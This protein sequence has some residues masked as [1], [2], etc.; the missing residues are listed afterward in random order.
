RAQLVATLREQ[1]A[2]VVEEI[3]R[4]MYD[5]FILSRQSEQTLLNIIEAVPLDQWAVALKGAEPP[6]R[7][8]IVRVMPRRQAQTFE[9]MM[10]RTG[11]VPRSRIEQTR[12]DIM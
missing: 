2:D 10:R 12:A 7:E 11:P 4:R 3:E 6:L 1:D 8:A 5:F 9:D